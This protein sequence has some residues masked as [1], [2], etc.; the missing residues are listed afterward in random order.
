MQGWVPLLTPV[1]PPTREDDLRPGVR[2]QPRQHSETPSPHTHTEKVNTG[3]AWW[4]M[5]VIPALW[6]AAAGRSLEIRSLRP[7]WATW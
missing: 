6:E 5:L 4:L 7:A 3:Q 2:G 1:I